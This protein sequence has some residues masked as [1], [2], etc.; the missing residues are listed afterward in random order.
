MASKGPLHARSAGHVRASQ[1]P[2]S[3][4]QFKVAKVTAQ[5]VTKFVTNASVEWQVASAEI[6]HFRM[7]ELSDSTS[8]QSITV[9]KWMRAI[10]LFALIDVIARPATTSCICASGMSFRRP[11]K[12]LQTVQSS[13]AAQTDQTAEDGRDSQNGQSDQD[14]A[15]SEAENP[16]AQDEENEHL[17]TRSRQTGCSLSSRRKA[18]ARHNLTSSTSL[19]LLM[20]R[21]STLHR[22]R[23]GVRFAP[24]Q[25]QRALV[26]RP[27][28]LVL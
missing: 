23:V 5:S 22:A 26:H 18:S 17:G 3:L 20:P 13:Q 2:L 9:E 11:F 12:T 16:T 4:A 6:Q 28:S 7:S 21:T 24:S 15:R 1:D 14:V 25:S 27:P 19:R 10:G 8:Y